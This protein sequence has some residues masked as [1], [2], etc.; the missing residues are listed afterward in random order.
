MCFYI[1]SFL[2]D[3][4][5]TGNKLIFHLP[6]AYLM[7]LIP[8]N[9]HITVRSLKNYHFFQNRKKSTTIASVACNVH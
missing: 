1:T 6:Q 4:S 9:H 5:A 3:V 7:E 8:K 2:Q